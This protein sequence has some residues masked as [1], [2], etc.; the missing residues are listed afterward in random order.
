MCLSAFQN[1]QIKCYLIFQIL[2]SFFGSRDDCH[3]VKNNGI[4]MKAEKLDVDLQII[5]TDSIFNSNFNV[6]LCVFT[7][8]AYYSQRER[9]FI[10]LSC[11]LIQ[12]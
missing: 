9:V 12:G 4:Q 8:V 6:F 3:T 11:Q 7:H 5:I 2:W 10:T 1:L